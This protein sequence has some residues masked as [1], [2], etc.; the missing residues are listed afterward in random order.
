MQYVVIA[1]DGTDAGAQGRRAAA[2]PAHI[3]GAKRM[4]EAGTLLTG[5]AILDDDGTMIGSVMV[6]DFAT[7]EDLD[8]WLAG[9]PYVTGNAWERIEVKP[10]R[11]AI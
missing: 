3:E 2:R 7:R 11:V 4:K 5:G 1:H 10:F 9:D 8:I 6:V